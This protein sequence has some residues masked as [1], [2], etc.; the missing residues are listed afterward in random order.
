MAVAEGTVV[1]LGGNEWRIGDSLGQGGFGEVRAATGS[2]GAQAALKFVP[3]DRK[4]ARELDV[5]RD[6]SGLPNVFPLWGEG[7]WSGQRVLVMPRAECDLR[8][9]LRE[10]GGV[11]PPDDAIAILTD[12]AAALVALAERDGEPI[13]HRNLKPE[14]ILRWNGRW[15]V[16]DFGIA[17]YAER[18]T[19][20]E[21]L[22]AYRSWP[23]AAP[24]LW[25]DEHA[26]S[27][28]DIYAVGIIAHELLTGQRPFGGPTVDRYKEQHLT[29]AAPQL[30]A[31]T[32]GLGLA[33]LIESCLRKDVS[34]RPTAPDF[35]KR[36]QRLA[37]SASPSFSSALQRANRKAIRE[38]TE[39]EIA[40]QSEQDRLETRKRREE[41][42]R[43]SLEVAVHALWGAL[44]TDAP[45]LVRPYNSGLLDSARGFELIRTS[46]VG[47]IV[48]RFSPVSDADWQENRPCF[49]VIG[50]AGILIAIQG[51]GAVERRAA[52]YMLWYCDAQE[53]DEFRWFELSFKRGGVLLRQQPWE[54]PERVDLPRA[55]DAIGRRMYG[56]R[57]ATPFMPIDGPDVAEFCQ[58]WAAIIGE[59]FEGKLPELGPFGA[60][61]ISRSY[62]C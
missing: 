21:T 58:R 49:E 41:D 30:D 28:T 26:E 31:D 9:Y 56:H 7:E 1:R 29:T 10:R 36:L 24:E 38:N 35:H 37:K 59:A 62:R 55:G 19:A 27:R 6:V 53:R 51:T 61:E 25:K 48:S 20:P 4:A 39:R 14:N 52:Y 42:A 50:R 44:S 43:R 16:A 54:E 60:G 57:L 15:C 3:L 46:Q 33:G 40:W 34:G 11:T 5:W 22:K 18:T 45:E 8:G 2:D 13:V 17:R 32:V 47:A 12:I 23:Y